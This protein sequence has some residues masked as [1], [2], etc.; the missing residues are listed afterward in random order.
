MNRRELMR[1][2]AALAVTAP[3]V[4]A[5]EAVAQ[6]ATPDIAISVAVSMP[7]LAD[8]VRNVAGA[9]AEVFSVMP[10]TADPHTWEA[11]PQDIVRA[12]EADTFISMG[13]N[14]EPFIEAGGWRRAIKDGG[15]PEL[16]L[17]DHV[18]LIAVDKVIDHGDHTH[19]LREGDPHIWLDPRKVLEAIPA[20]Q[21]H[22]AS[23]DP[24]GAAGY[25]ANAAAYAE[26][27]TTMDTEIETDLAMI[28]ADRRKLVVFHDAWTYFATR[29]GFEIIGVVLKNPEVEISAEE[30]VELMRIIEEEEIGVIFAEPHFNTEVLDVFVAETG[31]EIGELLTD[32]FAGRVANY[33]ELMR[34]NR[35]S[36]VTHL[37]GD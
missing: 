23:L 17:A 26:A 36:L 11:S 30:V 7:L 31:V 34:F 6:E 20:I 13:A 37:G 21:V 25:E 35:D 9:R 33:L 10:E 19:D 32:S 3:A 27:V 28:P 12:A 5:G 18:E 24:E 22:L 8:I 2:G 4:W 16:I 15:V 1:R 29:F 14:L